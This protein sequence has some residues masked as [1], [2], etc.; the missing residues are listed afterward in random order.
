LSVGPI[1]AFV[2]RSFEPVLGLL[3]TTLV[4][5]LKFRLLCLS[6]R[7]LIPLLRVPL[8]LG[9]HGTRAFNREVSQ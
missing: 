3:P 9:S 4:L 5:L 8:R 2:Q 6:L 1:D 7:L